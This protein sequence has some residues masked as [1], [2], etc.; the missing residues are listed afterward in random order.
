MH[1]SN[2]PYTLLYVY[3]SVL[4]S[5]AQ[6]ICYIYRERYMKKRAS[7]KNTLYKHWNNSKSGEERDKG[8][9]GLNL[10]LTR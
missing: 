9:T 3:C 8:F 2:A 10:I 4:G 1:G 7:L 6:Q 5:L